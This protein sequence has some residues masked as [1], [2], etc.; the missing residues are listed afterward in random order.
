[1]K[2]TAQQA[3]NITKSNALGKW[4]TAKP[5]LANRITEARVTPS[6]SISKTDQ[7]FGIGSCF[8]RN[9][10][11]IMTDAGFQVN[12]RQIPIP[13]EY[14]NSPRPT[15]IA[16][17]YNPAAL[18][19]ALH[20]ALGSAP[21]AENCLIEARPDNY[22]DPHIKPGSPILPLEN[23]LQRWS[24]MQDYFKQ[25]KDADVVILTLGMIE[26]WFD[27]ETGV[28]LNGIPVSQAI[29]NHPNRF[30]FRVLD[31]NSCLEYLEKALLLLKSH[32]R[33]NLRIVITTSP[34]PMNRTFTTSDIIIANTHSKSTLRTVA[35]EFA[36][37][38]E[39]VDYFPSYEF[40][41]LSDP[42]IA[43]IEDRIHVSEL[44]V[45]AIVNSFMKSYCQIL[46]GVDDSI[47]T[48][49]SSESEDILKLAKRELQICKHKLTL[50]EKE[51]QKLRAQLQK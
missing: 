6:F 27:L 34:V 39:N 4:E 9:I 24:L 40:V 33:K 15:G 28:Y 18:Y 37:K 1:M 41:M 50:Q 36:S 14:N 43:W 17:K 48:E 31:F 10:E 13:P 45:Q 19:Q 49:K 44:M 16:N 8:V 21:N 32:T 5:R 30:E 42:I 38:H 12:S 11:E 2:Y 3:L 29:K 20:F 25:V 22:Y 26:S 51:I 35:Q 47:E 23:A 46:T 7:I